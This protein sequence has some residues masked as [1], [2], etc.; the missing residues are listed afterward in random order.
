[1]ETTSDQIVAKIEE[2]WFNG[3]RELA[4]LLASQ[5]EDPFVLMPFYGKIRDNFDIIQV[6]NDRHPEVNAFGCP[7]ISSPE[8][9]QYAWEK[10]L[11]IRNRYT[12]HLATLCFGRAN[13]Q[14]EV[15]EEHVMKFKPVSR[16]TSYD[17][18]QKMT[19]RKLQFDL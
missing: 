8:Y 9:N 5:I 11:S 13:Q 16:L 19:S 18:S 4:V 1:M 12:R 2:F 15:V 3:N 10:A 14:W 17:C 6:R 7:T